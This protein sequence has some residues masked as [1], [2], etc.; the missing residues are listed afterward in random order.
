MMKVSGELWDEEYISKNNFDKSA[1]ADQNY[2][3]YL[4]SFF[5]SEL[6]KENA[7][8]EA[9]GEGPL[10]EANGDVVYFQIGV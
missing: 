4:S 3:F 10:C 1:I 9:R 5:Q 8:R 6:D 7:A 2:M